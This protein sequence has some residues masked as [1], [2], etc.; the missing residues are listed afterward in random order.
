M[1]ELEEFNQFL[2]EQRNEFKDDFFIFFQNEQDQLANE[3]DITYF[4]KTQED[5]RRFSD[6][7]EIISSEPQNK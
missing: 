1:H 2:H 6:D 7:I 3:T 5:L 4:N